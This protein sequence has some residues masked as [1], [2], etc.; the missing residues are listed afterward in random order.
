M[1]TVD[2]HARLAAQRHDHPAWRLLAA[3]HA[4]LVLGFLD[5]VFLTP[6]VRQLPA[7][8]LIDALDDHLW[9]LRTI[10]ADVYPKDADAYLA[11]WVDRKWLRRWYP[12]NTDI[13]H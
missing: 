3:D 2:E 7:P 12:A 6:N 13:A 1:V 11:D 10:D 8:E 5:R 4:P 9:A